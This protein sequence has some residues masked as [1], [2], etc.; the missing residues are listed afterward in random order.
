MCSYLMLEIKSCV[1]LENESFL[2]WTRLHFRGGTR[3]KFSK[4][5]IGVLLVKM[6]WI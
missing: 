4:I 2:F 1:S 6:G 3:V 5:L